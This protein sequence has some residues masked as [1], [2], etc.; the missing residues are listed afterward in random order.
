MFSQMPPVTTRQFH[1]QTAKKIHFIAHVVAHENF[2]N[3]FHRHSQQHLIWIAETSSTPRAMQ[4]CC[5]KRANERRRKFPKCKRKYI[6]STRGCISSD[7]CALKS[8]KSS[9]RNGLKS[10]LRSRKR[11]MALESVLRCPQW[12]RR[13]SSQI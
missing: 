13:K 2:I 6:K 7:H 12:S 1:S 3:I 8:P 10:L 5:V 9:P 4:S 11:L